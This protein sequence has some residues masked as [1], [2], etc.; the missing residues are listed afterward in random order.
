MGH[1]AQDARPTVAQVHHTEP[2]LASALYSTALRYA[3][4]QWSLN[5]PERMVNMWTRILHSS[6]QGRGWL[7]LMM[8]FV[9][10]YLGQD[11][12]AFMEVVRTDDSPTAPVLQL[13]HLD[14]NRCVRTGHDEF[15]V[16][17]Y[18][19][20]GNPHRLAWYQ[21]LTLCEMASPIEIQN[22]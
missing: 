12:G 7:A 19:R 6:Q 1:S 9:Q 2:I 8:P 18:D 3:G 20:D 13:N 21:V 17:Y 11:N 10:D 16:I 15:P 22:G 14:S 4:F 5:G